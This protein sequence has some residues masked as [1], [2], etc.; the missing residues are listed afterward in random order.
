MAMVTPAEGPS[1]GTAPAGTW[2]WTPALRKTSRVDAELLGVRPDEALRR[3]RR[4]A[5]HVAELAGQAQAAGA[6][7]QPGLD[8]QHVA[9]GLGPGQPGGHARLEGLARLLEEE[10]LGPEQVG[11][12]APARP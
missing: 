6:G 8:V 11:Q 10:P 1:L 9:A 2:M 7:E 5:H 3:P 12:V 4:L